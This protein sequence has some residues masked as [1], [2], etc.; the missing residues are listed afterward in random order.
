[1]GYCVVSVKRYTYHIGS[2]YGSQVVKKYKYISNYNRSGECIYP[3]GFP[4]LAFRIGLP[5][6]FL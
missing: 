4:F 2:A 6:S 5:V 1:M 3:S